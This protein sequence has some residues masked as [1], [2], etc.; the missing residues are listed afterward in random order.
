MARRIQTKVL[1]D[2]ELSPFR[3][4]MRGRVRGTEVDGSR[5]PSEFE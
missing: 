3:H 2:R 1:V 4:C 5:A